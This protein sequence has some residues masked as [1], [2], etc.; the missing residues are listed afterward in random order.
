[1]FGDVRLVKAGNGAAEKK[2]PVHIQ[3]GIWHPT[4]YQQGYGVAISE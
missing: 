1:M 4:C 2:C 3:A